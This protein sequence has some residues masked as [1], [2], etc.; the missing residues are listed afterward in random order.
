MA[1]P[2]RGPEDFFSPGDWNVICS[3]CGTKLKASEAV[4][5]WQGMWRHPKCNEERQP[6]DFVTAIPTP[7]M[8]VPWAQPDL[9]T[10]NLICTLNGCSGIPGVAMPGCS[11]PGNG[12][13]DSSNW[14]AGGTGN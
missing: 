12:N 2:R 8:A 4:K 14:A 1:G 10:D 3:I 7:E 13:W 9:D 11:L 5:N 6:Q